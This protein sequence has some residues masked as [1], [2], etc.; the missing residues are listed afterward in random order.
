L[1]KEKLSRL[2]SLMYGGFIAGLLSVLYL[3]FGQ[4]YRKMFT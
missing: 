2:K 1:E 4:M 3:V